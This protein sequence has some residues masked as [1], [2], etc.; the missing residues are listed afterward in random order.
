MDEST[1]EALFII[2]F[3]VLPCGIFGYLIAFKG[4]RG[5]ISGYS[6]KNFSNPQA[7][8]KSVGV[9]LILFS[10]FMVFIAY[11]WHLGLLT[12]NRMASYVLLLIIGVVLN[13]FYGIVKY[14]KKGN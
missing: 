7:F 13:Y 5:L 2:L 9:S 14:R 6:E 11:F 12:E 10:V 1:V 4:R 3:A 8:G